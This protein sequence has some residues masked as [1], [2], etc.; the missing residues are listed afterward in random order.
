MSDQ[1]DLIRQHADPPVVFKAVT[2]YSGLATVLTGYLRN[3]QL[4]SQTVS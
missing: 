2:D 1:A 4:G 3:S